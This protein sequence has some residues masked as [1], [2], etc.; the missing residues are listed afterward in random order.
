MTDDH[1]RDVQR[2]YPQVYLACHRAHVRA[3]ST[4]WRVSSHDAAILSH[5]DRTDG[6]SPAALAAHLGV[7]A[8]TL[9]ASIKRLAA[10]GYLERRVRDDD[11]R[12]HALLLTSQGAE[13]IASTSV[14]DE[15]RVRAL[16]RRLGDDDRA[17][18]VAGLRLL[19]RAAREIGGAP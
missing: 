5:L 17:A 3:G 14:L 6:M 1:V 7:V 19:A 8:S 4:A 15:T 9:S 12:R 18:A 13:A 2:F 10:L 11:R 16:L